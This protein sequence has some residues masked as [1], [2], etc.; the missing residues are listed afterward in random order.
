MHEPSP[1]PSRGREGVSESV[2]LMLRTAVVGLGAVGLAHAAALRK[3]PRANLV[4]VCDRDPG[5]LKAA[6]AD[7]PAFDSVPALLEAARPDLVSVCTAGVAGADH[8]EPARLALA[9]G[10]HVVVEPPLSP[11][12]AEAAELVALAAEKG[13]TLA[14]DFNQRFVPAATRARQWID[15]GRLGTPLF[16]NLSLWTDE[17]DQPAAHHLYT[18]AIHAVDLLR[19]LCGK[20]E[21]VQCFASRPAG[22]AGWSTVNMSLRMAG[23][24]VAHINS[25]AAMP[26]QHPFARV[27][28]AGNVARLQLDNVYEELAL[29]PHAEPEKTV[30]TNN[31][32]SG[33]LGY[34]ETYG[35]RLGRLLEQIEA[36]EP[37][38][39]SAADG[40]AAQRVIEAALAALERGEVVK[41]AAS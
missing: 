32:W 18:S 11:A 26:T 37:V 24:V 13:V 29:L 22:W 27:E 38:E 34:H 4:G 19:F 25:S 1:H 39:G 10:C 9:A 3:E 28:V 16:A 41:V 31:I 7:V 20:I 15:E 14:V 17:G 40:L 6:G 2:Y 5:R 36:G 33:L 30:I 23:G 12:G 21:S 8:C 35:L